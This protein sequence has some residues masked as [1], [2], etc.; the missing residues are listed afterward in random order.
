MEEFVVTEL[1]PDLGGFHSILCMTHDQFME[2]LTYTWNRALLGATRWCVN[3]SHR[4]RCLLSHTS[5]FILR[6]V[7]HVHL[8]I[9]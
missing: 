5:I 6:C 9:P 7:L 3:V 1:A 4:M 2:L 8:H